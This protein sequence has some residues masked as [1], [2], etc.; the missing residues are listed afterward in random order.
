M[1]RKPEERDKFFEQL[2]RNTAREFDRVREGIHKTIDGAENQINQHAKT[3]R[4]KVHDVYEQVGKITGKERVLGA[5][6]GGKAG[7]LVGAFGGPIGMLK[8]MVVGGAA[9]FVLGRTGKD[10]LKEKSAEQDNAKPPAANSPPLG[11]DGPDAS[12]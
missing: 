5:I 8:G 7:A 1:N 11:R 12:P 2:G 6:A 4:D 9:G 10:L 3:A